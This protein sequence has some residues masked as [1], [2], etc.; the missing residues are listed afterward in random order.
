MIKLNVCRYCQDCM[1]FEPR[2]TKRPELYISAGENYFYG[3][4]VVEC[5]DRY[6]CEVLYNH[7]KKENSDAEN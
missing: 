6:K 7:L 4:T 3:D 2:V 5:V 1:E